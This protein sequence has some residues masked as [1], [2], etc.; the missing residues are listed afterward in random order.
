M[1]ITGDWMEGDMF[2]VQSELEILKNNQNIEAKQ[3]IRNW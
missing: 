2:S 1:D 3:E